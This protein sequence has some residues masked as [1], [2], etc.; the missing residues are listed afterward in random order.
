MDNLVYLARKIYLTEGEEYQINLQP[1]YGKHEKD[2][3]SR[4]H[5][6][7]DDNNQHKLDYQRLRAFAETIINQTDS[8]VNHS[9]E[10]DEATKKRDSKLKAKRCK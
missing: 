7:D 9:F 10:Y 6:T 8:S 4:I 1:C 2:V 5:K 3:S